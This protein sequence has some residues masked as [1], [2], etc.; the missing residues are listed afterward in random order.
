MPPMEPAIFAS[1]TIRSGMPANMAKPVLTTPRARVSKRFFD[2]G[3]A[4]A[5]AL[6]A[7]SQGS[8]IEAEHDLPVLLWH[9]LRSASEGGKR[10]R[11]DLLIRT[12]RAFGG[13][14]DEA[15]EHVAEAIELLHAAFVIHD[16]VIDHDL[17]R[18]GRLNVSGSFEERALLAGAD[19][20]SATDMGNAAGIL[21][22]D[23]VLVG[24]FLA[25]ARTPAPPAVVAQLLNLFEGTVHVSAAGELRDVHLSSGLADASFDRILEMEEQ[26]TAIYSFSLPM[27]AA[28]MLVA[29]PSAL[30]ALPALDQLGKLLGTAFQLIDDLMG[31]FGSE[32]E[33]GKSVLTDLREGKLTPLIAH[34]RSSA[35]WAEIEEHHGNEDL[36]LQDAQKVRAALDSGGSK[37]FVMNLA[38]EYLA[39]AR[40]CA[41]DL[42][43]PDDLVA[44]ITGV[45]KGPQ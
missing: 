13:S 38:E 7:G 22:G 6:S 5:L 40:I 28:A 35:V 10:V 18:R 41:D 32:A 43:L 45:M 23:L 15:A 17:T 25:I 31:V 3:L 20:R 26:K 2:Q 16:D 1:S 39:A 37:E 29:S 19:S 24:A 36:T 12:Y 11:P 42:G 27:Q 44:W 21:G 4:R 14:E 9:A 30:A 8:G 33:T 34:A